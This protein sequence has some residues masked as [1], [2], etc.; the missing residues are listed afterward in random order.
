[1]QYNE[2]S[3]EGAAEIIRIVNQGR[4]EGKKEG[5]GM[6]LKSIDL[7]LNNITSMKEDELE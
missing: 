2:V 5:G 7:S 1:M 6:S 3:D 4:N